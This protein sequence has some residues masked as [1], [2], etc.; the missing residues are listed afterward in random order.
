MKAVVLTGNREVRIDEREVTKPGPG[1]VLVRTRA[2]AI[3]R[4][5]M[6]LYIGNS[7]IVGGESAGTGRI[8]PG[9]EPA[10]M[11][12]EVGPGGV[13]PNR[14]NFRERI[15]ACFRLRLSVLQPKNGNF[16]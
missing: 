6:S 4:S 2:S 12:A 8:V 7:T 14:R 1:A 5:D 16:Q 10:G 15:M 13:S 3:C 11:V 9:H